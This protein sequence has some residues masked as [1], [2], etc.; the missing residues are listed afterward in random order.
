MTLDYGKVPDETPAM[1]L[2]AGS[3][4]IQLIVGAYIRVSTREQGKTGTSTKTQTERCE[5][6]ARDMGQTLDP[7]Y[8]WVGTES[9]AYLERAVLDEV[10]MAVKNREIDVLIVSEIDRLSRDMIDP[11]IIVRECLEAGVRIHFVEGTNDTSLA[12]QLMMLLSGFSAQTE[13]NQIMERTMRGKDRIARE[14]ERL[15]SGTGKG[16]FGYDY[17]TN[18][19]RRVI[20]E[21]EAPVVKMMFQWAADGVSCHGI[22]VNLNEAGLPS[23]TGKLWVA[24]QVRKTLQ[25]QA[26]TGTQF[27]GMARYRQIKNG[28]RDMKPNPQSEWHQIEGFTPPLISPEFWNS[29]QEKLAV[30][31]AKWNHKNRRR[32][33]MTGFTYCGQCGGKVVGNMLAKGYS[34][35]RCSKTSDQPGRPATCKALSIRMDKLEPTAWNLVVEAVRNPNIISGDVRLHVDTGEGDTGEEMKKLQRE[36]GDLMKQEN[37]LLEDHLNEVFDPKTIRSKAAQVRLAL[38]EKERAL[39]I[40]KEQQKNRDDAAKAEE[41]VAQYCRRFSEGLDV[42]DHEGKRAVFAAFGAKF[43]VTRDE[44]QVSITVDPAVTDMSPSSPSRRFRGRKP[45]SR[46]SRRC[47]KSQARGGGWLAAPS[48]PCTVNYQAVT[49]SRMARVNWGPHV[50]RVGPTVLILLPDKGLPCGFLV[51]VSCRP[52][53][54]KLECSK[55]RRPAPGLWDGAGRVG[56]APRR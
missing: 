22:A 40:L 31:Q 53:E 6:A 14:G 10:R 43:T 49:H 21:R 51:R 36:I 19:K 1:D 47:L 56:I 39:E 24:D 17:D 45:G 48:L 23:R 4:Q 34:Y 50:A 2:I 42:L 13:R 9:G 41:R 12:G 3:A 52:Q 44:L 46:G 28:K 30:R 27:Y 11:V 15:P 20:N 18:L 7:R 37:K 29:V 35:Y 16:L 55:N 32:H 33:L 8:T 38:D 25:N 26:Y 5:Q 54:R